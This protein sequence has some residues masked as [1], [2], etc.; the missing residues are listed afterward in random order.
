MKTVLLSE[1][2]SDFHHGYP[3]HFNVCNRCLTFN[4]KLRH[5]ASYKP[6]DRNLML[7]KIGTKTGWISSW[8]GLCRLKD[9]LLQEKIALMVFFVLA[10]IKTIA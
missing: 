3:C 9:D 2:T 8:T 5:K 1:F 7:D 6:W 4:R 10:T